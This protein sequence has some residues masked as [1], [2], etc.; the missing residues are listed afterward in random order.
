[1][2][3]WTRYLVAASLA[4]HLAPAHAAGDIRS[5]EPDSMARIQADNKG[6]PFV[7]MVWSL[8]CSYCLASMK[9]LAKE[10]KHYPN[11]AVVTLATDM[12][13]DAKSLAAIRKKLQASGLAGASAQ[14]WAFGDAAPEQLRYALDPAWRGE[15]PRS[16]WFSPDGKGTA[17]SGMI[18][19]LT[20]S[21][22]VAS[23]SVATVH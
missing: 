10:K 21:E 8:D 2:K 6:K 15:V 7:L 12:K 13:S 18:D 3:S 22:F 9:V 1:M 14:A 20:V 4:A 11:L 16:Y 23:T 19:A 5:F 17:R